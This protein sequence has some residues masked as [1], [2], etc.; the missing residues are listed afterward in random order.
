M[1]AKVLCIRFDKRDVDLL[2]FMMELDIWY[3]LVL[4]DM[5]QF[6]IG[7]EIL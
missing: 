7:L 1:G 3:N 2:K 4:K 5:M 6:M